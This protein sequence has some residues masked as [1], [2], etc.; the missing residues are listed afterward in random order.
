MR[1]LFVA[2]S[3]LVPVCLLNLLNYALGLTRIPLVTCVVA[4]AVCMFSGTV[5]Y[6]WLGYAGRE[7]AVGGESMI[8]KSLLTLGLIAAV[9]FL[10]RFVRRLRNRS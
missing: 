2:F 6:T 4:S 10:P 5:A 3:R 8:R 1:W 7:A 9:A